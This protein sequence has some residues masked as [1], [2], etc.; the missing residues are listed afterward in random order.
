[1]KRALAH[2]GSIGAL[3]F[4]A[5]ALVGPWLAPRSPSAIDLRHAFELPSAAH[6]LGTADNGVDT[7]APP[8]NTAA[9]RFWLIVVPF[10]GSK[11]I[12]QV[13]L[14]CSSLTLSL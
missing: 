2:L 6:W 5:I 7:A 1:M 4:F 12:F 10:P 8:S 3:A 14:Y 9:V 13:C 11:L